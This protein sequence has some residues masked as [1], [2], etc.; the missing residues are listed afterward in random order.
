MALIQVYD[1]RTGEP[2]PHLVPEHWLDNPKLG[3]SYTRQKA[4][5]DSVA[6]RNTT[7]PTPVKPDTKE[8]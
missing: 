4:A 1:K 8:K 5:A 6:A 7:T 3:G 2:V